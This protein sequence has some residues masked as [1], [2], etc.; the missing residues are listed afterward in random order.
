[1]ALVVFPLSLGSLINAAVVLTAG[2][3]I[4]FLLKLYRARNRFAKLSG[5]GAVS[6]LVFP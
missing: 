1:M 3:L 6:C 5:N 4:S 2:L